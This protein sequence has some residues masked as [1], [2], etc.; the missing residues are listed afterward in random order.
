MFMQFQ[1]VKD[2]LSFMTTY[3]ENNILSEGHACILTSR[4]TSADPA[5][6]GTVLLLRMYLNKGNS[7]F[8]FSL[9]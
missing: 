6:E 2:A 8:V 4:N 9:F 5:E 3:K 1:F 7:F